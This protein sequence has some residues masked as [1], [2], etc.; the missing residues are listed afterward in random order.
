[1]PRPGAAARVATAA[2]AA[3]SYPRQRINIARN[4]R[5]A[6]AD[7]AFPL[8]RLCFGL[9]CTDN[10]TRVCPINLLINWTLPIFRCSNLSENIRIKS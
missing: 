9:T 4:G 3:T 7:G 5:L 1:M 8:R 2:I 6:T 10:D